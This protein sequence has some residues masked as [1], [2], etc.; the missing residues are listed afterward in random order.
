MIIGNHGRMKRHDH[1]VNSGTIEV[2][3]VVD[4]TM[5]SYH[6]NNDNDVQTYLLELM[7]TVC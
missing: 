1:I 2:A 4:E 6:D 7:N 5:M 3:L